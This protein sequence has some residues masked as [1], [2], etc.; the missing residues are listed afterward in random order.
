MV[1]SGWQSLMDSYDWCMDQ[2]TE[3]TRSL[4]SEYPRRS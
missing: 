2:V 4:V 1:I 3:L